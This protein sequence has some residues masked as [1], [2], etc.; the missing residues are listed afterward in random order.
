MTPEDTGLLL[1]AMREDMRHRFDRLE[2]KMDRKVDVERVI[3]DRLAVRLEGTFTRAP[4][5]LEQQG[6]GDDATID[7]TTTSLSQLRFRDHQDARSHQWLRS[8]GWV[9]VPR[10]WKSRSRMA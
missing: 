4:L 10:T 6:T 9:L 7:A 5:S 1:Q 2:D 8:T 3:T